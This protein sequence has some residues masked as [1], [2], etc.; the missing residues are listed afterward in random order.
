MALPTHNNKKYAMVAEIYVD[1][2]ELTH[3]NDTMGCIHKRAGTSK[4]G[5]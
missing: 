3:M 4:E 5:K 1:T 2:R